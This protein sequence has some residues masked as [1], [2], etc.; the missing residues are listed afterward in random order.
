MPD[1]SLTALAAVAN[2][3]FLVVGLY[4]YLS[5][6]RQI[7]RQ[8]RAPIDLSA[9]A[10][11]TFHWPDLIFAGVLSAFYLANAIFSSTHTGKL[12]LQTNDLIFN[13]LISA[14]VLISISAFLT[15]R[16]VDVSALAGFSKI[17][18]VR[19]IVTG[20][21]LLLAAYPLIYLADL[22]T[23]RAFSGGTSKQ[24]I[25]E[26]FSDS[27][28]LEQRVVIIILAVVIAPMVEEFV[29]RFY[30]YGVLK[31]YL[32]S[33]AGLLINSALFAAVHA[34]LPSAPPLFV[35]AACFTLAYEWSGSILVCMTM[36]SLFNSL[37]LVVLAFPEIFP[38]Q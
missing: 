1:G 24:G 34:H 15:L 14:V 11:K 7:G 2:A 26:L 3:L 10:R 28:T 19:T 12:V 30:L 22:I 20:G 38:Q 21:I 6:V 36:H 16:G 13:G 35:L 9:P 25:V 27:Q 32:G 18:I 17:G 29:F 23:Q 31:R 5:L 8:A 37:S 4:I 33:L